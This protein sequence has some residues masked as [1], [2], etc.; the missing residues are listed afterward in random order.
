[1][2]NNES[3]KGSCY[4]SCGFPTY[5]SFYYGRECDLV[6]YTDCGNY[7][8]HDSW[9]QDSSGYIH[10]PEPGDCGLHPLIQT[11]IYIVGVV[12]IFAIICCVIS[13]NKRRRR[14]A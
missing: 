8:Y 5:E 9:V 6:Y 4:D 10:C 12:L 2:G 7:L 13:R 3:R 14:Q 1:M 11:V